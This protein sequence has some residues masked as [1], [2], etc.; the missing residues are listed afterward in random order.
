MVLRKTGSRLPQTPGAG[1]HVDGGIKL[2]APHFQNF[3]MM[4]IVGMVNNHGLKLSQ[5][6]INPIYAHDEMVPSDDSQSMPLPT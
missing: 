6:E 3:V 4:P 5:D 2:G 1:A